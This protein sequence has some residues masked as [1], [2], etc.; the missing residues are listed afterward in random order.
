MIHSGIPFALIFR[1]FLF[2]DQKIDKLLV[3]NT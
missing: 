3:F 1:R 2:A